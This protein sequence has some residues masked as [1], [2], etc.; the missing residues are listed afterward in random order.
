MISLTSLS[1]AFIAGRVLFGHLPDRLGGARVAFV[2]VLI[3]A[4]GQALIWLAPGFAVA[5][6]GVILSGLGY[7]LVYPGLGIEALRHTPSQQRGVAMGAYSAFLDLS[8]GISGPV[9]GLVAT[10]APLNTVFFVSMFAVLAAAPVAIRLSESRKPAVVC[11]AAFAD[12][13]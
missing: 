9:L 3:E 1:V 13:A 12:A 10:A 2:C 8:L 7:S 5:L 11:T 4:I 6:T